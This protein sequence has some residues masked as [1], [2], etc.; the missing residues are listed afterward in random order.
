MTS[1]KLEVEKAEG[2]KVSLVVKG[3]INPSGVTAAHLVNL[4]F[5]LRSF[6]SSLAEK[7]YCAESHIVDRHVRAPGGLFITRRD[8]ALRVLKDPGEALG[9]EATA[10]QA[11]AAGN[12]KK[13][14]FFMNIAEADARIAEVINGELPGLWAAAEA[15]LRANHYFSWK[16][17]RT[18]AIH[19]QSGLQLNPALGSKNAVRALY[20]AG[21]HYPLYPGDPE[22]EWDPTTGEP[23]RTSLPLTI[24]EF[25]PNVTYQVYVGLAAHNGAPGMW[26]VNSAYPTVP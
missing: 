1:L 18:Y 11:A 4:T 9:G 24:A 2:D 26:Y 5:T 10:E 13:A 3:D 16:S 22:Y 8:L 15:G 14:G 17:A 20:V 12:T 25:P 21:S 19:P 6:V 7:G 23:D